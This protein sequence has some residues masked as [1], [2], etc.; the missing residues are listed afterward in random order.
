MGERYLQDHN[1]GFSLSEPNLDRVDLETLVMKRCPGWWK[2]DHETPSG[3]HNPCPSGDGPDPKMQIDHIIELFDLA[4]AL[5]EVA[6]KGGA[7]IFKVLLNKPNAVIGQTR[8][9]HITM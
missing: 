6:M 8:I 7:M 2:F 1:P 4:I 5:V 9:K 3:K